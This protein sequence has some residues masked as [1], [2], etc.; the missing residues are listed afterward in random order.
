MFLPIIFLPSVLAFIRGH[1]WP[2]RFP[3]ALKNIHQ[4]GRRDTQRS[5]AGVYIASL[6]SPFGHSADAEVA[7]YASLRFLSAVLGSSFVVRV[8]ARALG[9]VVPP[10]GGGSR[11]SSYSNSFSIPLVHEIQHDW[12]PTTA[13]ISGTLVGMGTEQFGSVGAFAFVKQPWN[14]ARGQSSLSIEACQRARLQS[15]Q[16]F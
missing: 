11:S 4:R 8:S 16:C 3:F 9:S 6:R 14:A 13:G 15:F 5:E 7:I 12:A 10:S 2:F 1:S